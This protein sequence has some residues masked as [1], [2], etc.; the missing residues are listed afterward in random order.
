MPSLW[1]ALSVA[2]K[3]KVSCSTQQYKAVRSSTHAAWCT[4]PSRSTVLCFS[5]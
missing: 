1:K 4:A 5:G 3:G 2:F